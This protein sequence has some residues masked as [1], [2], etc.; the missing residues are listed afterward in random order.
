MF[1]QMIVPY[2]GFSALV[3]LVAFVVMVNS[4]VKPMPEVDCCQLCLPPKKSLPPADSPVGAAVA[5]TLSADAA[6]VR[7]L[8][9][10]DPQVLFECRPIRREISL[11]ESEQVRLCTLK[12]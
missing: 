1:G 10:V 11:K 7:L 5:E 9:T 2:E 4:E 3:T 6:Q 12:I 8:A